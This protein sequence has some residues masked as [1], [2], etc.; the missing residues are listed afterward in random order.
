MKPDLN[1]AQLVDVDDRI[2]LQSKFKLIGLSTHVGPSIKS[3]HYKATCKR[4]DKWIE[5]DDEKYSEV[6]EKVALATP[7]YLVF[8]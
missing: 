2:S 5:F 3:G 8:Y 6:S 7:A 4:D 1:M